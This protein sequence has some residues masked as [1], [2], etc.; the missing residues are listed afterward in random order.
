MATLDRKVPIAPRTAV[1]RGR[2]LNLPGAPDGAP[3]LIGQ[4]TPTPHPAGALHR[5]RHA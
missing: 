1:Y 5:H 3:P 2:P 4:T